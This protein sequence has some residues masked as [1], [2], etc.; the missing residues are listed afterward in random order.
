MKFLRV[1]REE[2]DVVDNARIVLAAFFG[3]PR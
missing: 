1:G 3:C 2:R